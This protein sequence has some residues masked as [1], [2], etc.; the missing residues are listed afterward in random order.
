MLF[1]TTL[2]A[3]LSM[4]LSC[5]SVQIVDTTKYHAT[6]YYGRSTDGLPVQ[7]ISFYM[8]D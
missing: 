8:V 2:V 4:V 5:S 3:M 1:K 7:Y 6:T